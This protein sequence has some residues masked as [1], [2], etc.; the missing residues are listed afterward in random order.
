M[1]KEL[2]KDSE[3][4]KKTVSMV[5]EYVMHKSTVMSKEMKEDRGY[6]VISL[7]ESGCFY[8][9]DRDFNLVEQFYQELQG[10]R[11]PGEHNPDD[12]F[13]PFGT[14]SMS[15]DHLAG[16]SSWHSSDEDEKQPP[17]PVV[18]MEREEEEKIGG[19]DES[20]ATSEGKKQVGLA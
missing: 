17:K 15:N 11:R 20:G 8:E 18:L 13:S 3:K 7:S 5:H 12:S 16:S 9:S 10:V 1:E 19:S 4:P 6:E 2:F 14:T